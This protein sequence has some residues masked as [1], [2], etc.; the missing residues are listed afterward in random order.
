MHS[1]YF[2]TE[3]PIPKNEY[4]KFIKL[5]CGYVKD[6]CHLYFH[7]MINRRTRIKLTFGTQYILAIDFLKKAKN[8][9]ACYNIIH[10]MHFNKRYERIR[11]GIPEKQF[12]SLP[13]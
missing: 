8:F 11:K 6:F 12:S 7:T 9:L 5:F 10:F 13:S 2:I 3:Q 4:T 1:A